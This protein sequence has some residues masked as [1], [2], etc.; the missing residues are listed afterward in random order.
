M[1]RANVCPKHVELILEIKKLLLL[2]LAGFLYYFT[3]MKIY[4]HL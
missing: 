3:Y 2:H 4:V 1:F